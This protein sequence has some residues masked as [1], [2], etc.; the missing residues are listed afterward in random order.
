MYFHFFP[1]ERC[2]LT[3]RSQICSLFIQG[4]P[5]LIPYSPTSPLGKFPLFPWGT[6]DHC[7]GELRIYSRESR[8]I[9]LNR[10]PNPRQ[11]EHSVFWKIR[12]QLPPTTSAT[13]PVGSS[14]APSW[15]DINPSAKPELSPDRFGHWISSSRGPIECQLGREE[16]RELS[17]PLG[18]LSDKLSSN[19]KLLP[20]TSFSH[21]FKKNHSFLKIHELNTLQVICKL[22]F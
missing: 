20:H 13:G 2:S 19:L 10:F 14:S 15:Q 22:S 11:K 1:K 16:H 6:R 18:A 4:V 17:I 9:P 3:G 8:T 12:P 5:V 21:N 7:W